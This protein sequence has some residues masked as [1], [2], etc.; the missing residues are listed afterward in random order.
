MAISWFVPTSDLASHHQEHKNS[1]IE[2]DGIP[3]EVQPPWPVHGSLQ[4]DS[5]RERWPLCTVTFAGCLWISFRSHL[6]VFSQ[7]AAPK[8]HHGTSGFVWNSVTEISMLFNICDQRC[9]LFRSKT[10]SY[11][12]GSRDQRWSSRFPGCSSIYVLHMGGSIN[13]STPESFT[14]KGISI[15]NHPF[16]GTPFDG[17]L[18]DSQGARSQSWTALAFWALCGRSPPVEIITAMALFTIMTG[19]ENPFE[20]YITNYQC[21]DL[22]ELVCKSD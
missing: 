2:I 9:T 15:V 17:N 12:L 14:L 10:N 13:G 5:P 16:W 8:E 3:W 22:Y 18:R 20:W 11:Y 7:L 6:D 19:E 21:G 1:R 4:P